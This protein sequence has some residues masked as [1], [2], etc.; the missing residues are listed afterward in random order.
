MLLIWMEVEQC[1]AKSVLNC[2]PCS[3]SAAGGNMAGPP[4][5]YIWGKKKS[6]N[7]RLYLFFLRVN[8]FYDKYIIAKLALSLCTSCM[9]SLL[10]SRRA[11]EPIG[12]WGGHR[13]PD[14][15]CSS[16]SSPQEAAIHRQAGGGTAAPAHSG[17][18]QLSR[19]LRSCKNKK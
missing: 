15:G 16:S 4:W 1:R 14:S 11:G 8:V 17:K 7:S 5:G 12:A 9:S 18:H 19:F 10:R 3:V 6:N 2:L 13:A